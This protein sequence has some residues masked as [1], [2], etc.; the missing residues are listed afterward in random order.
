MAECLKSL[1]HESVVGRDDQNND[2]G[3]IR[4]ACSHGRE[5]GMTRCVDEGDGVSL[6][7]DR[8]GTDTLGDSTRFSGGDLG[9]A[10]G[11]EQGGL[12]VV[13]MAHEGDDRTA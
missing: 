8:V 9:A 10:D 4:S 2:V 1:R 12:A 5:S 11:I 3:D 13:D 6:P 7:I